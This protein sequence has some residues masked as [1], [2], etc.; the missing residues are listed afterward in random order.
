M[1]TISES[2]YQSVSFAYDPQPRSYRRVH[3]QVVLQ[4]PTA[5]TRAVQLFCLGIDCKCPFDTSHQTPQL[6]R[7][8]VPWQ[9][10]QIPQ[11]QIWGQCWGLWVPQWNLCNPPNTPESK[12][13]APAS[14]GSAQ[15]L[16]LSRGCTFKIEF[17]LPLED[18]MGQ[19]T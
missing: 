7:L 16:G 17:K 10:H 19:D 6:P 15:Q 13:D 3:L 9:Q 14:R 2:V 1:L 18:H 4:V 11:L 5:G 12:C 8:W